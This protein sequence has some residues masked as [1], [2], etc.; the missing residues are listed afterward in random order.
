MEMGRAHRDA[1]SA[2]FR[3]LQQIATACNSLQHFSPSTY[4]GNSLQ[5]IAT[6]TGIK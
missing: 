2:D 3:I 4:A 1:E 6:T 5:Q